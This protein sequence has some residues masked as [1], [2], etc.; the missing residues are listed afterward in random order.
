MNYPD[1]FDSR[2]YRVLE[3]VSSTDVSLGNGG[4]RDVSIG[5]QRDINGQDDMRHEYGRMNHDSR[6][7]G[8]S[9]NNVNSHRTRSITNGDTNLDWNRSGNKSLCFGTSVAYAT[10]ERAGDRESND[11]TDLVFDQFM[12]KVNEN[13]QRNPNK[14]QRTS[15]FETIPSSFSACAGARHSSARDRAVDSRALVPIITNAR[16][17][18]DLSKK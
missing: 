5:G 4:V 18:D 8:G 2:P 14:R 15:V 13:Q 11:T 10:S 7:S 6:R 9:F 12:K 16:K 3:G 17:L 1:S